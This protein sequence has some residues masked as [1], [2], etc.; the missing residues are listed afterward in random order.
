MF[1]EVTKRRNAELIEAAIQLHQTG[2]ILPDTYVLDLD[3]IEANG[4]Q[5][6]A[7]AVEHGIELFYMTKQFGR[8]P[9]IAQKLVELGITH[10]VVVDFREAQVMMDHHLPLGNVGHLVQIP[11][12]LLETVINYGS[13]YITVYS[14]EMLNK[15][16]EIA[17]RLGKKQDVLIRI[18]SD[19]DQ[20]YPGQYGGFKIEEL[21]DQLP[22]I[23]KYQSAQVKGL[24]SFPCFLFNSETKE[25]E[26]TH[27]VQTIQKAQAIFSEA[28]VP[29]REL[30]IPSAT[31]SETI[32]FIKTLGGTQGEPGHALT[33]TTPMHALVDL[34]EKPAMVYVSEISH[35]FE[36]HSYCFG[37][38]YY[39]RGHLENVLLDNGEERYQAKM[40]PFAD[41]NID[42]YL[43]IKGKHGIGAT[44]IMAFR[45]QI[46]VTR[47]QVAVVSGIQ[48]GKP[49]IE[50]IYDSQGKLISR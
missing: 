37:G 22:E 41:E 39:R 48:V 38:G 12:H 32:P 10:A 18:V 46:F 42:Y 35:Q 19:E 9:L 21:I 30:N 49:K 6:Q 17:K 4:K 27:N 15:I 36:E 7:A 2:A 29:L 45:T 25:L 34:P 28:G 40:E 8:N 33:G 26:A 13:K 11:Q 14:L 47:S 24:T 16:D 3:S 44:A 20:L 1:M 43:G 5:M 50:G 23:K 31:C